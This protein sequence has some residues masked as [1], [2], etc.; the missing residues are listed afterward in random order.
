MFFI[1]LSMKKYSI[2]MCI[3][4]VFFFHLCLLSLSLI[5]LQMKQISFNEAVHAYSVIF[6]AL[7]VSFRFFFFFPP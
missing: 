2:F 5:L 7:I 1:V 6:Q 3:T 4:C